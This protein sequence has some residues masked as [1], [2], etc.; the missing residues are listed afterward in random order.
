MRLFKLTAKLLYRD[1]V[2][3]SWPLWVESE[4][5]IIRFVK[6][7]NRL[8]C[9]TPLNF[10]LNFQKEGEFFL[11][12]APGVDDEAVPIDVIGPAERGGDG[13]G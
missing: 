6:A 2:L 4:G 11:F 3:D 7:L 5:D 1:V 9:V 8:I 12:P 10:E 13:R